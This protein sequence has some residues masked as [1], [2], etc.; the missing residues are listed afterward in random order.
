M[1]QTYDIVVEVGSEVLKGA[2]KCEV[3][4]ALEELI[5][6]SFDADADKVEVLVESNGLGSV[7]FIEVRD[8][9]T[10]F[11]VSTKEAFGSFG[12]SLKRLRDKTPSGRIQ[13]G[14]EGRGRYKALSL[15]ACVTWTSVSKHFDTFLKTVVTVK[16]DSPNRLSPSEEELADSARQGTTVR[17]TDVSDEASTYF[18]TDV[19]Q[20]L[21]QRFAPYLFAYPTVGLY[22]NGE[23]VNPNKGLVDRRLH[24]LSVEVDGISE[25]AEV[26]LCVWRQLDNEGRSLSKIYFCN[27]D[28]FAQE[29][30][31]GYVRRLGVP[32]TAYVKSKYFDSSSMDGYSRMGA[33]DGVA[34]ELLTRTRSL[35][36]KLNREWLHAQ[37]KKHVQDLKDEHLYPF[38]GEPASEV[39]RA[40]R[41][42]FDIVAEQLHVLAP[43]IA[44]DRPADRKMK[45]EVLRVAITTEPSVQSFLVKEVMGLKPEQQR[46]L[47][48]VLQYVPLAS[49]VSM[50]KTVIDR[51]D[52]LVGLRH[53]LFE[54]EVK[55]V[56]RERSQLHRI[57][58][59]HL[60]IFGEE[61]HLAADD[62][63]LKKVLIRHR[64]ILG[65]DESAWET[66]QEVA[67]S[68]NDIPDL[69]LYRT[70]CTRPSFIEHVVIELKAPRVQCGEDEFSQIKRYAR[71][72]SACDDFDK[73]RTK[74]KFILVNNAFKQ[75]IYESEARQRGREEGLVI[76][77]ENYQVWA[78]PWSAVVQQAEGRHKFL[79]ERLDYQIVGDKRAL[80]YLRNKFA[81]FLPESMLESD[82]ITESTDL[83]DQ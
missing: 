23:L 59:D 41:E 55:K 17:I 63:T 39:E 60:W 31:P 77:H 54:P 32:I 14:R 64:E 35:I 44:Q 72:V 36:G 68:L 81:N 45:M 51:L 61:Y 43:S 34:K 2:A 8:D 74:W 19:A 20:E 58:V 48:Q 24:E 82:D 4:Q 30:Q 76:D 70:L 53:I 65:L 5:W 28:G 50:A 9:G 57:L 25:K 27:Q 75:D 16:S 71:T 11:E 10:G 46:E 47:Y 3:I 67:K 13:H 80:E 66:Q 6:N 1:A 15:G 22:V 18:S 56:L 38:Q 78:L 12:N 26:M 29:S 69:V 37:A 33:M 42:V 62:I 52:F 40:E 21:A 79:K 73:S 83:D 49:V 7:N